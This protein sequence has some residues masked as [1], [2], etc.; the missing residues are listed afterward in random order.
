MILES[1][2][3]LVTVLGTFGKL[4]SVTLLLPSRIVALLT[5]DAC[6]SMGGFVIHE[7]AL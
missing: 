3:F 1:Q 5:V 6:L 7:I 4:V 2:T